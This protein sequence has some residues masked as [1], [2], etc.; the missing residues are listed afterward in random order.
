[1]FTR[2][3]LAALLLLAGLQTAL[4]QGRSDPSARPRRTQT[5]PVKTEESDRHA[6][7]PEATAEAKRLYKIG[8][9]YGVAG[10]FKQAAEIFEQ[11]VKLKPDYGIAYLG[12]GHAYYDL[13]QWERAI[14]SL[15]RGLALKPKDKDSQE[16]LAHAR[17]MFERETGSQEKGSFDAKA[18]DGQ[19]TG[20]E[21]SLTL[22]STALPISTSK[23]SANDIALTKVYRVGPGDVL[24]VRLTESVSP[25]STLFTLTPAGLLEHPDLSAP[26]PVAG[27]TVEEISARIESDLKEKV[28]AKDPKVSIGVHEYVSHTILVSGLVKE[29]GTKILQREAIPLYVV[30]ADAQPLPEAGRVTVLRNES[31]ESF[32]IDLSEP[33]E[34]NILVRRGDVITLQPDPTQFFYLDGEVNSPGEKTL[35][36]GLTLTQAIITAGG[37]TKT[38]KEARLARD[39]GKG[40]LVVNHYKFKDI[41]SGKVPDPVIQP[42]DRVTIIE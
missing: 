41:N 9:N 40:F 26:L 39:N 30:V 4:G 20:S 25:Q 7:S 10:L 21:I 12:L 19:A 17:L 13:Q 29:P 14:D 11:A 38:A 34:M 33:S 36:R 28:P 37:L 1:M 32:M 2:R 24:D 27:L 5:L 6:S 15:E 23:P 22:G 3:F 18:G 8:V 16:R 31:N 35:R 42:G